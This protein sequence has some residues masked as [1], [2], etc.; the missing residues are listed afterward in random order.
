[1]PGRDPKRWKFDA[2]GHI[3]CR[4]L[5]SC[6]GPLC[7]EYDHIVPFSQGGQTVVE[8]CQIL[9]TRVNRLKSDRMLSASDPSNAN[10]YN[11]SNASDADLTIEAEMAAWAFKYEFCMEELDLVEMAC[12]GDIK[13]YVS[14]MSQTF[15]DC[16]SSSLPNNNGS[17]EPARGGDSKTCQRPNYERRTPVIKL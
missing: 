3:V 7:H 5:T 13:R 11:A 1:V 9:S 10:G 4:A 14:K 2:A 8:N 16:A 6:A 12:Y 17:G 15:C